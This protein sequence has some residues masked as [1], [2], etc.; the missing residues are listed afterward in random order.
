M[1]FT[2][3]GPMRRS[4]MY[5]FL[6][7]AVLLG[8]VS[9]QMAQPM[10]VDHDVRV[11]ALGDAVFEIRMVF[12]A[13]QF[14]NWQARYGMNPSLFRRDVTRFLTPYDITDFGIEKNDMERSVVVR[15]GARGVAQYKGDGLFQ[16]D[17]PKDWRLID[18]D[19]SELRFT[20]VES[21]GPGASMMHNIS[22]ELP[23]TAGDIS[24]PES[25]GSGDKRISYRLPV[26]G[27]SRVLL[28]AG[29]LAVLSGGVLLVLGTVLSPR[30]TEEG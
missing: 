6:A 18:Q 7:A 16:L 23:E 25:V 30:G 22:V 21:V 2:W 11:D 3:S 24:E 12:N 20:Q 13:A 27:R 14:Q 26:E 8:S 1:R 29:V 15:V 28:Y 9:A 5:G 19:D 10:P 17:V 4:M